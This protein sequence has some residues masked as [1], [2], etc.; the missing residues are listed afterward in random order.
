[1]AYGSPKGRKHRAKGWRRRKR[2]FG[3][4]K[5]SQ[6]KMQSRW[7]AKYHRGEEQARK[8]M[9]VGVYFTRASRPTNT[10]R[11]AGFWAHACMGGSK[12]QMRYKKCGPDE[13]GRT[14]T[15]AAKKALVA[16]GRSKDVR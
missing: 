5:H 15:I 16:L 7:T 14:P 6:K 8:S 4:I 11:V 9:S 2:G 12:S 1:M 10:G 13:F 3:L